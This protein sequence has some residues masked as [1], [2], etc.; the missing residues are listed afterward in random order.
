ML[1]DFTHK[2]WFALIGSLASLALFLKL[3]S[4]L[5]EQ[6]LT[7]LDIQL[8][9]YI[10]TLR[11]PILTKIMIF[12][13]YLG[14]NFI[15]FVVLF[16]TLALIFNKKYHEAKL[17]VFVILLGEI[18]DLVLKQ[19]IARPRPLISPLVQETSYSFPSGHSMGSVIVYLLL[20]YGLYYFTRNKVVASAGFLA[21]FVLIGLIGFSRVYLGVH[22]PSDVFGGYIIGFWWLATLLLLD[23]IRPRLTKARNKLRQKKTS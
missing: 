5:W 15:V 20:A 19:L 4:Y 2:H 12:T 10:Y 21:A 17:F 9:E 6:Q 11:T 3:L 16:T 1:K 22:Y 14:G 7:T 8:S 13:S 23:S 18:F